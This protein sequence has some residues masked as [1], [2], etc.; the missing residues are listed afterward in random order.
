MYMPSSKDMTNKQEKFKVYIDDNFH[1]MDE[2]NR[3][4]DGEYD[5]YEEAE[6][7]CREIVEKSIMEFYKPGITEQ[8]LSQ[9]YFVYGEEPFVIPTPAGKSFSAYTHASNRIVE[10]IKSLK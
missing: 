2:G 1:Y 5:T 7:R 9:G 3:Q 4:F 8:E 6:D 10:I